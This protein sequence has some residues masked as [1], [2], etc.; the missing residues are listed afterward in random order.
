MKKNYVE[1]HLR[2]CFALMG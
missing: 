1:K 2:K